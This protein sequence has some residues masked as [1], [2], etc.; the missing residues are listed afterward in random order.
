[1]CGLASINVPNELYTVLVEIA[2]RRGMSVE[3]IIVEFLIERLD[4]RERFEM[5]VKLHEKYLKE[6]EELAA[7]GDITQASEKLWGA[8]V[9]LLNA[10]GERERLP[11][12]SHRDLKEISLYLTEKTGDPDYTRLFSSTETLHANF[13]HNFLTRKTFEI[14]REDALKLIEKLRRYLEV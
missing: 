4:P 12:Y 13:Y 10:I 7:R 3:D 8:I 1:M 6:A 2:R 5:Y 9:R 11:H 14:H